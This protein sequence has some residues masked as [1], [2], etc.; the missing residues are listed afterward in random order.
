[1]GASTKT[2]G[3]SGVT[4]GVMLTSF[5]LT[6]ALL[7]APWALCG[8]PWAPKVPPKSKK[9]L[10]NEVLDLPG[11]PESPKERPRRPEAC[12]MSPP[13]SKK[14]AEI[15]QK[16]HLLQR[17]SH[18][19]TMFLISTLCFQGLGELYMRV[20]D[21]PRFL[22]DSPLSPGSAAQAA[23]PLQYTKQYKIVSVTGQSRYEI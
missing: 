1:M 17:A 16:K 19:S 14:G 4:L 12:K 11:R 5:G 22:P 13:S 2:F 21:L 23:R 8:A 3:L 18:A 9:N 10:Y 20:P 15:I 7:G 6:G